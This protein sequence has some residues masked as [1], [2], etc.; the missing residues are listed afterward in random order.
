MSKE[1][2]ALTT[3]Q[4]RAMEVMR[5][6]ANIFL[7]GISGTG[8]S[9]LINK[10]ISERRNSNIVICAPTEKKATAICGDTLQRIFD[11]PGRIIKVGEYN[12]K[13]GSI[14]N[15]AD[16]IIIDD[17]NSCRV[18]EFEYV[19][20]TLR[21]II[22]RKSLAEKPDHY[23][24]QLILIGDFYQKPPKVNVEDRSDFVTEWGYKR[25]EDRFAFNSSLWDDLSLVNVILKTPVGNTKTPEYMERLSRIRMSRES[26]MTFDMRETLLRTTKAVFDFYVKIAGE[27]VSD[28]YESRK[29]VARAYSGWNDEEDRK[30]QDEWAMG[31]GLDEIARRHGRT[32][33]AIRSRLM[34]I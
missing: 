12:H 21:D 16:I 17:I 7:S 33:G 18:D 14:L 9:F 28:L 30:V 22:K 1:S 10:F 15:D 26:D 24:K 3:D 20:R 8:K 2:N 23:N 34:Q 25:G 6:G 29:I 13:P 31:M 19:I 5:T 27:A 4:Q 32:V 11:I